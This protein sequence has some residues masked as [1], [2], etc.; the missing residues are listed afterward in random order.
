M[1]RYAVAGAVHDV[2][3]RVRPL[4]RGGESARPLRQHLP[5]V[6]H[7]GGGDTLVQIQCTAEQLHHNDHGRR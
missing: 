4:L 3:D 2:L 5:A 6:L 7:G 1:Y